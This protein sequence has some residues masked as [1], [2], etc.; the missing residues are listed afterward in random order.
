[1]KDEMQNITKMMKELAS[2]RDKFHQ[3]Y[4]NSQTAS[5]MRTVETDLQEIRELLDFD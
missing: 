1:M 3:K 4:P 2:I 5:I